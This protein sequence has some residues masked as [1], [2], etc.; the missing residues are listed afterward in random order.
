MTCRTTAE[1][2]CSWI[3]S[4]A[5]S[6]QGKSWFALDQAIQLAK[7]EQADVRGLIVVPEDGADSKYQE[8]VEQNFS[9]CMH[10]AELTGNL[11]HAEGPIAETII[12]RSRV[13]DL[14]VIRLSHPPVA[15]IF[16]RLGSGI[17]TL[18]RKCPKPILMVRNQVT[19]FDNMLLAYDGSEKG[20]EA[21]YITT[22]LAVKYG[23]RVSVL[24]VNDEKDKG[25][26][27]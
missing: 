16:P 21:L 15:K 8:E 2:P 27:C 9:E 4:V 7:M 18:V 5:I 3:F 17:R 26:L 24:V 20:K 23:K 14:V 22:Y 10:E 1:H 11:V 13:N 6:G 25:R 19:T 12:Q